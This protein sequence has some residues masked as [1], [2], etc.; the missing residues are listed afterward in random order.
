V[1]F[2][3]AE[4]R[5]KSKKLV[6]KLNFPPPS[7]ELSKVDPTTSVH[8]FLTTLQSISWLAGIWGLQM[9]GGLVGDSLTSTEWS[10]R[11]V[12]FQGLA[13]LVELAEIFVAILLWA[14]ALPCV[15]N[16]LPQPNL[17]LLLESSLVL[18][19]CLVMAKYQ[20]DLY[21]KHRSGGDPFN[22]FQCTLNQNNI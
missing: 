1:R 4:V 14:G 8:T 19:C 7:C 18:L 21:N 17:V 10:S 15:S 12:L 16:L 3:L 22:I 11:L 6:F 2:D 9:L 20:F 13:G 5:R